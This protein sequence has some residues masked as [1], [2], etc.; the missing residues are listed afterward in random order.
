MYMQVLMS[1]A[2]LWSI[3]LCVYRVVNYLRIAGQFDELLGTLLWVGFELVISCALVIST[4]RVCPLPC[5]Y[6][7]FRLKKYSISPNC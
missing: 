7:Y 5:M 2:R 3:E 6:M 4:F 1:M